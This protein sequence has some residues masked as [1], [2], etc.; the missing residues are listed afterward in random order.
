[1]VTSETTAAIY[2]ALAE[3][4]KTRP[5][6]VKSKQGAR[7][8]YA[9][10]DVVMEAIDQPLAD[11]G[12]F[13]SHPMSVIDGKTF[14]ETRLIHLASGEWISSMAPL[15]MEQNT[16]QG[17]GSAISY[18]RRY[19]LLALLGIAPDDDD[20]GAAANR[21]TA[22]A[23]TRAKRQEAP[24]AESLRDQIIGHINNETDPEKM[25]SYTARIAQRFEEKKLSEDDAKA[26][27]AAVAQKTADLVSKASRGRETAGV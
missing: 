2:P 7:G 22:V 12:L 25:G 8:K 20:D 9:P 19:S 15:L 14:L 23:Q 21:G 24:K 16:N 6:V 11:A 18:M 4:R 26:C 1:M 27:R 5:A 17:V 10:L 13:V 3:F